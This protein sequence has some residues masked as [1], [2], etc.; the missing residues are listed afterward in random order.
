MYKKLLLMASVLGLLVIMAGC[1]GLPRSAVAEVDG[2]VITREDLDFAIQDYKQQFGEQSVPAEGTP[3]YQQLE[4]Q[5]VSRLVDEEVLWAE[6]E[7]MGLEVTEEEINA[8]VDTAE[9]QVGG[10]EALQKKL[11][12]AGMTLDRYKENVR[13]SLL[14]QKIYPEVTKDVPEITDEEARAYYDANPQEFQKPETRQVS[15]IL[16]STEEEALQ[17]K[18]RLEA[19]EDFATVAREVSIDEGTKDQGGSLGEVPTENSGFVP[20]FE[21]AMKQLQ[22]GQISDPVQTQYGYHI[23]LVEAINPP[24]MQSFDEVR[25]DLKMGLK[26]QAE[27]KVFDAWLN[28]VRSQHEIVYADEFAPAETTDTSTGAAAAGQ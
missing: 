23:I 4:K 18:A 2:K 10:E 22:V 16:V 15:H 26:L 8:K 17:V 7:K 14:F 25:D 28:E 24:G 19:G 12:E 20:E 27:R 21:N 5:I 1:G 3:E 9:Q 13:K 6:A 11:D